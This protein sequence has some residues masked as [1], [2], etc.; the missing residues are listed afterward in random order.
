[1]GLCTVGPLRVRLR[2]AKDHA[3]LALREAGDR[4]QVGVGQLLG[5]APRYSAGEPEMPGDPGGGPGGGG[6]SDSWG[7]RGI[8]E[9]L[10]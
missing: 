4:V 5:P 7:K 3:E 9:F 10:P 6:Y 2:V 8:R 1:M